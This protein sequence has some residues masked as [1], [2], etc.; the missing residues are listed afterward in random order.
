[1]KK[2]FLTGLGLAI[3]VAFLVGCATGQEKPTMMGMI[4]P[5]AEAVWDYMVKNEDNF[6]LW[7]GT[8]AKQKGQ[9]P[10]GAMVTIGMN[11]IAAKTVKAGGGEF[12]NDAMIV[13]I[14]YSP[15]GMLG[16]YTIMLKSKGYDPDNGD[17]YWAK[18]LGDGM[19]DK[20]PTGA[21][22]EGKTVQ[23]LAKNDAGCIACHAKVAA[24][25]WVFTAIP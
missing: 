3:L 16:A 22:I 9:T 1:M 14:N 23:M 4:D 21:G 7:P 17:W 8:T 10:H 15:E 25:D 20:T 24:N 5:N 11:D 12:M 2:M 6:M 13:K 18:Y 19:L